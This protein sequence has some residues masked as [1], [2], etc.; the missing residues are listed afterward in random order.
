MALRDACEE[1][2]DDPEIAR[3]ALENSPGA[4]RFCGEETRNDP[5]I[6]IDVLNRCKNGKEYLGVEPFVG[7][8]ARSDI[9]V[10]SAMAVY[11]SEKVQEEWSKRLRELVCPKRAALKLERAVVQ[12]ARSPHPS[13]SERAQEMHELMTK[14]GGVL[15]KRDRDEYDAD[16][17]I[18]KASDEDDDEDDEDDDDDDEDDEDD[19]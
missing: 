18:P 11:E 10:R 3:A 17:T 9:E 7:K 14:P 12:M 8:L 16:S 15:G 6:V 4:L 19:D 1:L 5:G 13:V 2:R